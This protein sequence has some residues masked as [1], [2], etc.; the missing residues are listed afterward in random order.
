ML[1]KESLSDLDVSY[2]NYLSKEWCNLV[3]VAHKDIRNLL[4]KIAIKIPISLNEGQTMPKEA[5]IRSCFNALKKISN[6]HGWVYSLYGAFDFPYINNVDIR[7]PYAQTSNHRYV[8]VSKHLSELFTRFGITDRAVSK[9]ISSLGEVWAKNRFK[10]IDCIVELDTSALAFFNLGTYGPDNESCFRED[11]DH[12]MDKYNLG[13]YKDSYVIKI[14]NKS[15]TNIIARAL[16]FPT[17][18]FTVFNVFNT[19]LNQKVLTQGDLCEIL[20]NFFCKLIDIDSMHLH[21]D[22]I[23]AGHNVYLNPNGRYTFNMKKSFDTPQEMLS[24]PLRCANCHD[25]L[26]L[27]EDPDVYKGSPYCCSCHDYLTNS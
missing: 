23:V 1:L 16:G 14:W 20:R 26:K 27:D 22:L 17:K 2:G 13:I 4:K 8:K 21:E 19:Y 12:S 18:Q 7:K 10:K 11:H 5:D 6:D 15:G 9:T 25:M 3:N 24:L